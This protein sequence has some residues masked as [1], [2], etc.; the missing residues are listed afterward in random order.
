M[1]INDWT[2][3]CSPVEKTTS[4][5][6]DTVPRYEKDIKVVSNLGSHKTVA[7]FVIKHD[8]VR[9]PVPVR[10]GYIE[11]GNVSVEE[12]PFSIFCVM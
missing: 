12:N 10:G 6:V 1:K 11:G 8:C 7:N 3:N 5:I 2:R 9:G 4:R